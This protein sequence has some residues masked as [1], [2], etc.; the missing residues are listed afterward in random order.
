MDT[1]EL[2]HEFSIQFANWFS[3]RMGNDM[4]TEEYRAAVQDVYSR[5]STEQLRQKAQISWKTPRA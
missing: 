2:G 3:H 1:V 4:S 5:Y